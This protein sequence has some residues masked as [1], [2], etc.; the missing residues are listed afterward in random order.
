MADLVEVLLDEL[1][2]LNEFD[3]RKGLGSQFDRLYLRKDHDSTHDTYRTYL[4]ETVL[5]TVTDVDD[6]DDLRRQTRVEHVTLAQ[7][8]LEIGTTSEDETR[9][10]DL[11]VRD[12][13]LDG[14]LGNLADVVVTLLVT[15]TGETQSRLTTTA[16][17]LRQVD[18]EFVNDLAGVACN[19]TEESTVTVHDDEAELGVGL[20]ELGERFGVEFVVTKVKRA[21]RE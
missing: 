10:V 19:G 1:L 11:V 15:K 21:D 8:S 5:T 18:G 2:L 6:L 17:L 13:V 14:K 3:V 20:E 16:V 4:V 9:D 12:E 7:L